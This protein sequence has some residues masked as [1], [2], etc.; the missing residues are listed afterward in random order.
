MKKS[1]PKYMIPSAFVFL[2]AF[3]LTPNGKVDRNALPAPSSQRAQQ[4]SFVAPRTQLEQTIAAIWREV[5]KV[6][7]VGLD[8][9]FFDLGGHSLSIVKVHSKLCDHLKC[10]LTLVDLF[11]SPTIAALADRLNH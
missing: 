6:D 5:L 4:I 11:Q 10:N 1:L 2:D 3:P 9:N 7:K 8:D